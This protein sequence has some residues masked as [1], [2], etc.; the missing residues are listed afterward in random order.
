MEFPIYTSQFI[1]KDCK[2]GGIIV[3]AYIPCFQFLDKMTIMGSRCLQ[4]Y[5][6][7]YVHVNG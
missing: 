3:A 5:V 6:W 2:K 4:N 1:H 7:A